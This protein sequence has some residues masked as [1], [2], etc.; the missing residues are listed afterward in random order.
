MCM[1]CAAI[2]MTIALGSAVNANQQEK[3][4]EAIQHG[5][6]MPSR[7]IPYHK[8]T[9]IVTGGLIVSSVV[10]HTVIMPHSGVVM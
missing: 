5:I 1:F 7:S 8:L 3:R 2:P 4:R 6:P 10:Y 9:L